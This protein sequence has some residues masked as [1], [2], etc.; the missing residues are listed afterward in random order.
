MLCVEFIVLNKELI[1]FWIIIRFVWNYVIYNKKG[2]KE[3]VIKLN[4]YYFSC[5]SI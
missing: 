3:F 4:E 2:Y 1:I 5:K